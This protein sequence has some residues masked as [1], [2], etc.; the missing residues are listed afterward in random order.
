MEL[1]FIPPGSLG[2]GESVIRSIWNYRGTHI[3]GVLNDARKHPHELDRYPPRK[4]LIPK[5]GTIELSPFPHDRKRMVASRVRRGFGP[6]NHV[7]YMTAKLCAY[8]VKGK[9]AYEDYLPFARGGRRPRPFTKYDQFRMGYFTRLF[10]RC[11]NDFLSE[12][13]HQ[14]C[15]SDIV[16]VRQDEIALWDEWSKIENNRRPD[17]WDNFMSLNSSIRGPQYKLLLSWCHTIPDPTDQAEAFRTMAALTHTFWSCESTLWCP[18]CEMW[19]PKTTKRNECVSY[20]EF[21]SHTCSMGAS[22]YR[23]KLELLKLTA[24]FCQRQAES[25]YVWPKL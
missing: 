13:C 24:K 9:H 21:P 22:E 2:D 23:H 6:D 8:L 16:P 14:A 17:Y 25:R 19:E 12:Y 20:K 18:V 1:A 10:E 15:N 3:P 7:D 11:R 4:R 5:Q